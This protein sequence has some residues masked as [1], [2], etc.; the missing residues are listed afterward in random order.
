MAGDLTPTDYAFLIILRAEGREIS[1]TEMEAR[2]RV[3]LT[4]PVF[5]KLNGGG[6]VDSDTKRRPY[7]HVI[8]SQGRKVLEE[9][10]AVE[11]DGERQTAKEKVLWAALM[12]QPPAAPAASVAERI[13][14]AYDR[15]A[16]APGRWVELT[17]LRPQ[18][19]GV[20]KA[21][22]D[23]ALVAMLDDPDVRLEPE[24]FGHRIDGRKREASVDVGGESRHKLAIGPR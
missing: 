22:V 4:G 11:D 12:A 1:N 6:Y 19:A 10:W 20:P 24:T 16:G 9:P 14:A 2:H 5:A 15:L 18:L 8:T 21:E 23:A 13:R 7:R 17:D 3:R